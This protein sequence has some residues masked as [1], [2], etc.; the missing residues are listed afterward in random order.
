MIDFLKSLFCNHIYET[1]KESYIGTEI[2][3]DNPHSCD[4][5]QVYIVRQRCCKC[6]K[7]KIIKQHKLH[8]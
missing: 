5:M 2:Q 8:E 1:I 4:I 7:V 3:L 6:G